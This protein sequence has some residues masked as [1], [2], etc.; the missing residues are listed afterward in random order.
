MS[1][2]TT[3]KEPAVTFVSYNAYKMARKGTDVELLKRAGLVS[4][5]AC[6]TVKELRWAGHVSRMPDDQL[7]KAVL[8]G[9]LMFGNRKT[10]APKLRSK[11]A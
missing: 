7:L 11:M 6:I 8:L 10:G 2:K 5:E 9:E 3:H 1:H 4:T